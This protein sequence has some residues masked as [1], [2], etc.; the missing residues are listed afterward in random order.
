MEAVAL[1]V[2]DLLRRLDLQRELR[3]PLAPAP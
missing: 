1:K 3:V 2:D